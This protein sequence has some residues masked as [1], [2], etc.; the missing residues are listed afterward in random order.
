MGS[1]SAR[2]LTGLGDI[3]SIILLWT[4]LSVLFLSPPVYLKPSD[5]FGFG[6]WIPYVR[7]SAKARK[8]SAERFG[9]RI[10]LKASIKYPK[11]SAVNVSIF[12]TS[13]HFFTIPGPKVSQ[14]PNIV[15]RYVL[16]IRDNLFVLN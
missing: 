12:K 8:D 16:R 9:V 4:K 7:Y 2:C 5:P 14:I 6:L 13:S 3:S 1:G 15:L 10:D 11:V